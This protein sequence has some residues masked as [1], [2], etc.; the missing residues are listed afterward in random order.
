MRQ[1]LSLSL[2]PTHVKCVR[3]FLAYLCC[4]L[5]VVRYE[6]EPVSAV[7]RQGLTLQLP[8]S[9]LPPPFLFRSLSLS[10]HLSVSLSIHLSL[11]ASLFL[12]FYLL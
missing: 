7:Y 11:L 8:P 3:S 1:S 12:I 2:T 10:I 9:I 4:V 6:S 5:V